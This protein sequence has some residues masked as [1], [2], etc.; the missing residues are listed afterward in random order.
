[1]FFVFVYI[2]YNLKRG[3]M[4]EIVYNLEF[5]NKE[6]DYWYLSMFTPTGG[7]TSREEA[8]AAKQRVEYINSEFKYKIVEIVN[9][10]PDSIGQQIRAILDK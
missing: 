9:G 8:L 5:S 7:F 2:N 10:K 6:E 4:S 3:N 1:M